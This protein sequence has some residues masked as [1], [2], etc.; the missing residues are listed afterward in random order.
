V[1]F[2]HLFYR[3]AGRYDSEI[4]T[5]VCLSFLKIMRLPLSVFGEV[6]FLLMNLSNGCNDRAIPPDGKKQKSHESQQ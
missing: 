4:A 1:F 5:F 2:L 3:E 6:F